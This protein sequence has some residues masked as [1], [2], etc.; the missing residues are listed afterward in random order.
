VSPGDVSN[1][2]SGA[3]NRVRPPE[4]SSYKFEVTQFDKWDDSA[5]K[6]RDKVYIALRG[7]R[8]GAGSNRGD[9]PMKYM[10]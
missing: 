8:G 10:G 7:R 2:T 1:V 5:W 3:G 6:K 9:G 4:S